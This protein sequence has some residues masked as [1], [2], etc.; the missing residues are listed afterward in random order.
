MK[1]KFAI[2][3]FV[4]KSKSGRNSEFPFTGEILRED[5]QISPLIL[6][7]LDQINLTFIP[8]EII[9]KKGDSGSGVFL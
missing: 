8:P 4:N 3:H 9:R 5:L 6:S 7:D 2:K 1:M